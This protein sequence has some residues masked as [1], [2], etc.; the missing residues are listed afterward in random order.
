MIDYARWE[1]ATIDL[2]LAAL[3]RDHNIGDTSA[4][5]EGVRLCL[6][7]R[8]AMPEWLAY[9]VDLDAAVALGDA[10]YIKTSG[11]RGAPTR[12]REIR[13]K[14]LTAA[15][16]LA[17]KRAGLKDKDKLAKASA[18]LAELGVYRSAET[19]RSPKMEYEPTTGDY[20][21]FRRMLG[22]SEDVYGYLIE[23]EDDL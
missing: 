18:M 3:E 17:C 5:H 9:H 21:P 19:L 12:R 4:R 15:A 14:R 7:H 20:E 22:L 13:N 16:L 11:Q 6:K 8:Y 23:P 2:K 10:S 1:W